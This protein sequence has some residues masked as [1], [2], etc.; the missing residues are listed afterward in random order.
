MPLLRIIAGLSVGIEI[1]FINA[2]LLWAACL[3]VPRASAQLDLTE[4]LHR[5]TTPNT[6]TFCGQRLDTITTSSELIAED[7]QAARL[8]PAN[9]RAEQS[10]LSIIG[11]CYRLPASR[12][13][14][15]QFINLTHTARFSRFR[16]HP[17]QD[18]P[19]FGSEPRGSIYD[20][21]VLAARGNS[22]I[23]GQSM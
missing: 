21:V 22:Q 19:N 18:T 11:G 5:Q 14:T 8:S 7:M 4:F 1:D 6:P 17:L 16:R 13:K 15:E 9:M 2:G 12:R 10:R 20:P 23:S 3:G